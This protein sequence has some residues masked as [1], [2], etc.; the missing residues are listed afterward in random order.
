MVIF[1]VFLV[2]FFNQIIL[3]LYEISHL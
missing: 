2:Y 1:Y 3:I